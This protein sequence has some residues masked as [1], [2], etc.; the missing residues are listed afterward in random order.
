MIE[1]C[2]YCH[3]PVLDRGGGIDDDV[4]RVMRVVCIVFGVSERDLLGEQRTPR[5]AYA[6]HVMRYLL[7]CHC[8]GSWNA[9]DIARALNIHHSTVQ[10]SLDVIRKRDVDTRITECKDAL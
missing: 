6:R 1:R 7:A 8:G 2:Q 10:H 3:A 5:I 4:A 9:S